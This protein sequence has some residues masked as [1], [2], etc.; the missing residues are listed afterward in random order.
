MSKETD[1]MTHEEAE[2]QRVLIREEI[3]RARFIKQQCLERAAHC[4]TEIAASEL[5]LAD[6][7]RREAGV[8][9]PEPPAKPSDDGTGKGTKETPAPA[10][11]TMGEP[12]GGTQGA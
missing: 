5:A 12:V 7:D 4:D 2:A 1:K 6:L 10:P 3:A 11:T 8:A 9:F